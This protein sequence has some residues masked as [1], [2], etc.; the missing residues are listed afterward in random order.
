MR[1]P[2][3]WQTS[4]APGR[5]DE[6]QPEE[7]SRSG[8][9]AATRCDRPVLRRDA[10]PPGLLVMSPRATLGL[11]GPTAAEVENGIAV[12]PLDDGERAR[13]RAQPRL[14]LEFAHLDHD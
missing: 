12:S 8:P 3:V 1:Q 13:E 11:Y 5:D 4:R 6:R 9:R 7:V 14:R 10:E 2:A